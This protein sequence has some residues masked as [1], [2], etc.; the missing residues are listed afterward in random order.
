MARRYGW[1][2]RVAGA[3]AL[4]A[5]VGLPGLPVAAASAGAAASVGAGA[6][7]VAL[8]DWGRSGGYGGWGQHADPGATGTVGAGT[9]TVDSDP[10][11][12]AESA[13]VV[14]V[15]T[16]L[17]Y[18]DAAGAGTGIVLTS[19]GEILTNYHV[20]EGATAIRVTVASTGD[21]YTAEVVGHSAGADV[22]LLQL[23]GASGLTT[24]AVD[25]DTLAAGDAVTAV[26]NA[27]GTGT[28]T[29]ADGTV[30]ALEA[31]ITTAAEG[32][33][34]GERLTGLIETDA[35]VVAGDSGGPLVD[36]EGEVV[37]IDTAASSGTAIDGYAIPIEDA[38][39][40]VDQIT[41]GES[42]AGVQVGASAFLGVQVTDT[43]T[44]DPGAAWGTATVAGDGAL[45]AG[46]VDGSPAATAGLAAADTITAVGGDAVDSAAGLSTALEGRAVG[47]RVEVTWTDASGSTRTA[48]VTLAASP[49]A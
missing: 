46:V 6:G 8:A 13:G 30:T 4:T 14:L 39:A 43:A 38:L 12:A 31:S 16:V 3:T 49:T 36:A 28:L 45:V 10:A 48:T 37:G 47:D 17:G 5:A 19:T 40:V 34:A 32:S 24:A 26:G 1:A 33:V 42:G 29:A 20:V 18:E 23:D 27:G 11:T 9:T 44:A 21:T 25:D 22:A 7:V 41:S 15:D 35:D 2:R